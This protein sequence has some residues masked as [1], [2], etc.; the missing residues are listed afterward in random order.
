[1]AKL[2]KAGNV[3]PAAG[4]G[5]LVAGTAVVVAG[6][7]MVAGWAASAFAAAPSLLTALVGSWPVGV[8]GVGAVAAAGLW[9]AEGKPA[10]GAH[11]EQA[12]SMGE[13][14]QMANPI[15]V[16]PQVAFAQSRVK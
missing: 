11:A 9:L 15:M 12:K 2:L 5:R 1:M 13:V 7:F 6:T 10:R 16:S 14:S 8:L 4:L 3:A